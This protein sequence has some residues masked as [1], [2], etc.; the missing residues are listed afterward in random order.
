[1]NNIIGALGRYTIKNINYFLNLL[2][3]A[4]KILFLFIKRPKNGWS[5]VRKSIVDQ[6]YFT[7]IQALPVIIIISLIIGSML[8]F[9]LSKVSD[10]YDLGRITV[11]MIIR[12]AGPLAAA[13]IVILRS[14]VAVTI[15]IAQMS[16]ADKIDKIEKDGTDPLYAICFPRLVG[17]TISMICL[18]FIF[19]LAA[20][21]GGYGIVW[22]LTS[23]PIEHFLVHVGKALTLADII[24]GTIKAVLFGLAISVSCLYRGFRVEKIREKIPI[25]A[26]RAAMECFF[27]C[28]II[29]IIIS[30]LFYI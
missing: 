27:L 22:A 10:Q 6:I 12:E 20:I 2:A 5:F 26:S 7:A 29:N 30:M 1:M 23:V 16:V 21:I 28:I 14:A 9:Q 19:D 17:I 13:L 4:C 15:G 11:L 18:F 24:A 3:F 8:T 25:E